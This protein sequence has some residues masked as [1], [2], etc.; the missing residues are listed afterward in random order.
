[1]PSRNHEM[2]LQMVRERP[3]L[4]AD[5]LGC[6]R[7]SL[8]PSFDQAELESGDLSERFRRPTTP[9]HW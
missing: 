3:A 1:M 9:T 2:L 5:L 4:A 7:S 6:V 8:V